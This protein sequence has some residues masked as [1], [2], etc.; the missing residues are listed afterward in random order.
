[1]VGSSASAAA[2]R[3]AT[4]TKVW[5]VRSPVAVGRFL[6]VTGHYIAADR[7]AVYVAS[8]EGGLAALDRRTGR[9]RWSASLAGMGG[10]LLQ[11][12]SDG[13]VVVNSYEELVG[14]DAVTGKPR[15]RVS[16]PALGL[17]GYW[18][19]RSVV[20]GESIL[21]GLS[22]NGEGDFRPPIVLALEVRTGRQVWSSTLEPGTD[23][24]FATP[25][26]RD[27]VAV[28]LSTLSSPGSASGNKVHALDTASGALRWKV[29]LGGEQ[30]FGFWPAQHDATTV[31]IP[32]VRGSDKIRAVDA[33]T[34]A[35]R[36]SGPGGIVLR[37]D[38]GLWVLGR[39][40]SLVL[41]DPTTGAARG[42]SITLSGAPSG[43]AS[44]QLFDLGSGKVAVFTGGELSVIDRQGQL[45]GTPRT[46]PVMI[47]QP[48]QVGGTFYVATSD[49]RI[50]GYATRERAPAR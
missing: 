37:N 21:V 9:K 32:A 22:G 34:G 50:V 41:L 25:S 42:S 47:D 45:I 8:G 17:S 46:V 44:P 29:D 18:P 10:A 43:I 12:S 23:L 5:D 4:F 26:V 13:I 16:L 24:I 49:G 48:T 19:G 7:H 40:S 30:A 27:G 35:A 31:V 38:A 2:S 36:W 33:T 39:D 1:M 20:A 14:L 3:D 6:P 28:F 15:W 11:A